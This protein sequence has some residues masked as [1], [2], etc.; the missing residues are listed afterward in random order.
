MS[1]GTGAL[2]VSGGPNAISREEVSMATHIKTST[3]EA[4]V[5]LGVVVTIVGKVLSRGLVSC[6]QSFI[7][8]HLVTEPICI[9]M[10]LHKVPILYTHKILE[11]SLR[12]LP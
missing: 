1:L 9:T 3:W 6:F 2:K 12:Q 7:L 8:R 5:F 4:S 11:Y 10:K